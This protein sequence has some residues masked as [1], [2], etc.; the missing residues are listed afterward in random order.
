MNKVFKIL[1]LSVCF[2]TF[3]LGL[4][5]TKNCLTTISI[6]IGFTTFYFYLKKN[7][8]DG[9]CEYIAI[10]FLFFCLSLLFLRVYYPSKYLV[11]TKISSPA[12]LIELC[13]KNGYKTTLGCNFKEV[14]SKENQFKQ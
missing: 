6:I 2:F 8:E 7:R 12:H 4:I 10:F 1:H 5:L 9:R 11:N 14:I 13:W 3:S